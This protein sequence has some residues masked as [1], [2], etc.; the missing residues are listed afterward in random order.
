[1]HPDVVRIVE[2]VLSFP[3]AVSMNSNGILLGSSVARDII[4]R[5]LRKFSVSVDG[6]EAYYVRTNAHPAFQRI[7][8]NIALVQALGGSVYLSCTVTPRNADTIVDLVR[9]AKESS[10][11][12]ISLSRA[13]PIGRGMAN[14]A[15]L[16]VPWSKFLPIAV[17][18]LE[19]SGARF[20]VNVE[21]NTLRHLW[22]ARYATGLSELSRLSNGKVWEGFLGGVAMAHVEANGNVLADPF[23]AKPAGNIHETSFAS[24]WRESPLMRDMRRRDRL[25]GACGKCEAKYQCGGHRGRAFAFFGDYFAE[26]PLCP[27]SKQGAEKLSLGR[28]KF[29]PVRV[30]AGRAY[31]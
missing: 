31:G 5:G 4:E 24:I 22:D 18:A 28:Y 12:G 19:S 21:D 17:K 20:M 16:F 25:T 13:Y 23:F 10:C 3:I 6:S 2:V 15:D 9:F 26:D 1:V 7:A 11:T 27:R 30:R 8:R 14:Y 29:V